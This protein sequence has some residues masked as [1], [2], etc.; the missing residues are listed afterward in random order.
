M[1][2]NAGNKATDVEANEGIE[3]WYAQAVEATKV[4]K[5]LFDLVEGGDDKWGHLY[6]FVVSRLS[7]WA[8]CFKGEEPRPKGLVCCT[9]RSHKTRTRDFA[10]YGNQSHNLFEEAVA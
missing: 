4:Y 8:C 6:W 7:N 1:A 3:S 2:S 9:A 5:E 10:S